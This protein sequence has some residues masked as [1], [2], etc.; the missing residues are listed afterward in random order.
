VCL[1]AALS[2]L[3]SPSPLPPPSPVSICPRHHGAYVLHKLGIPGAVKLEIAVQLLIR[4]QALARQSGGLTPATPVPAG[5]PWGIIALPAGS[6][7]A[8]RLLLLSLA[9]IQGSLVAAFLHAWPAGGQP[10]FIARGR[11]LTMMS[12]CLLLPLLIR[13]KSKCRRFGIPE[14]C[15]RESFKAVPY[16]ARIGYEK[17]FC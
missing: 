15:P 16:E 8:M 7:R 3:P 11:D 17:A 14:C 10:A 9:L 4:L 2:L 1:R 6:P 13:K 12:E 5:P